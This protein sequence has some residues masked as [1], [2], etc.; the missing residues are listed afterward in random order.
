MATVLTDGR[1]FQKPVIKT[2]I[3]KLRGKFL[4]IFPST[5]FLPYKFMCTPKPMPGCSPAGVR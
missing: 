4:P 3:Y 2:T 1:H 5:D